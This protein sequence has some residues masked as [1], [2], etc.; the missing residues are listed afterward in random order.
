MRYR[1]SER[2]ALLMKRVHCL[3][4]VSTRG[5]LDKEDIPMQREACHEFANSKGWRITE[6]FFE[7]GVSGF[8]V[9]SE[10]REAL[11]E[12]KKAA[13]QKQFDILLVFMFDRLGRRDDETPFIVEWFVKNGIEVWS[14]VEGEQRFEDHVDKLLN[15]IRYWQSSGESVK[16]SIRTKTR[17]GQLVKEGLFVGG[18]PPFGYRL[19]KLGRTNKHG[20][21]V[22]DL[23]INQEEAIVVKKI[24]D[25]YCNEQIGTYK[26]AMHLT[27]QGILTRAGA[28][29]R[30][31]SILNILKNTTYIGI[32]KF[33]NIQSDHI[34]HLQIIDN[35]VFILAQKQVEK[36]K[37]EQPWGG[38][39]S[40][41]VS[42]VLLADVLYCMSCGK[43]MTV[44][45]NKKVRENKNGSKVVYERM[46]YI[47][48]NKS[49]NPRCE[50]Q[51]N[52][53]TTI[54]DR[55]LAEVINGVLKYGDIA[56]LPDSKNDQDTVAKQI[57]DIGF[58]LKD[59]KQLLQE[60]KKEVV[61]VIRGSSAFGSVLI[62]DLIKSSEAKIFELENKILI[63][64][65]IE[66][67]QKMQRQRFNE[68]CK[69]FK[70]LHYNSLTS[71]ALD[72]QREMVRQLVERIHLGA[73]Y[74]Y[75]IEWAFGGETQGKI[76]LK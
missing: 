61:E 56:D 16:A 39:R 23:L 65:A 35:V 33:G 2:S 76:E 69:Q 51:K 44:T 15:Y 7:K 49:D 14:V 45:L 29:W 75:Q 9:P 28:P 48:I 54:L 50:G 34:P 37:L 60:L 24:F 22:H 20:F 74:K 5:Q 72:E 17:M 19:C 32:R 36:N 41:H 68:L 53:S 71:L 8:N 46:K 42:S 4:R 52:Y 70:V 3:Y 10:K 40:K 18:V 67:K 47:C 62:A 12:L 30:N 11:Q 6:E 73:G 1:D 66:Q 59:E 64:Y 31:M 63:L 57:R 13:I 55:Y 21:E 43:K 27:N 38:R 26:I 25:L 58:A